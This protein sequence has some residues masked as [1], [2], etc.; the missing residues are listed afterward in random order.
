MAQSK[1]VL[2]FSLNEENIEKYTSEIRLKEFIFSFDSLSPDTPFKSLQDLKFFLDE[3]IEI[4]HKLYVIV[5]YRS[6]LSSGFP[7][8]NAKMLKSIILTYPEVQ[9]AF[10]EEG[11]E[12]N[13]IKY[14]FGPKV[15]D[16][17]I[18]SIHVFDFN[19]E[20][21]LHKLL[22]QN[23]NLFDASNLRY[24]LKL[25]KYQDLHVRQNFNKLQSRRKDNLA[26]VIDEERKQSLFN[27]YVLYASG[28]RVLPITTAT[29][30]IEINNKIGDISSSI[31]PKLILRDYDLQ[32]KD[33]N[34][35]SLGDR[36][37]PAIL[38]LH[39]VEYNGS[40]KKVKLNVVDLIR[41][42]KY[43]DPQV[44][45]R[46]TSAVARLRSKQTDTE[47]STTANN[48]TDQYQWF[49]FLDGNNMYWSNMLNIPTY[50]VTKSDRK[51]GIA[52]VSPD[53]KEFAEV[54]SPVIEGPDRKIL[55][56]PGI[57]K[58][59]TGIYKEIQRIPLV[60]ENYE[61]C[62]YGMYDIYDS[63]HSEDKTVSF[64]YPIKTEREANN[65]ST[66]L[67]LYEM[68]QS[69]VKRA[70]AYYGSGKY[71]YAALLASE[72]IEVM[73][74]FHL[75]L[76]LKAYYINAVAENALAVRLLGADE[77]KLK[78]DTWFRLNVKIE[79]DLD[80]MCMNAPE[81]KN[82]LLYNI[83]NESRNFSKSREQFESAEISLSLSVHKT[84]RLWRSLDKPFEKIRTLFFKQPITDNDVETDM[85]SMKKSWLV[86]LLSKM[87]SV[88]SKTPIVVQD[89]IRYLC[90][91]PVAIF[92]LVG[93]CLASMILDS[94]SV[95]YSYIVYIAL[96]LTVSVFVL[97]PMQIVYG[98]VGT[99]GDIRKFIIMFT[100][101]IFS[102]T[103][104]YFWG[105]LKDAGVTYNLDVPQIEY[106]LFSEENSHALD[107]DYENIPLNKGINRSLGQYVS[108]DHESFN[109]NGDDFHYYKR[110][111][112]WFVLR[113]T[114]LS[115]MT[116]SPSDFFVAAS[117]NYKDNSVDCQMTRLFNLVV[118]FQVLFSW[119]FLGVFISL[120][121]QKFRNE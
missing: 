74:G 27:G 62:R 77:E 52:V 42:F 117:T 28:Y 84:H 95:A 115:A 1:Y 23:N 30:L 82:N 3:K 20:F 18:P 112:Y 21:A 97:K 16:G 43:A 53:A 58:P 36:E 50:F 25:K 106:S 121:Y 103:G 47:E 104:I 51:G 22:E 31:D 107:L 5:D 49:S 67:D 10:Q 24:H 118:L 39:E 72:A 110:I 73:N 55:K 9:F 102:F 56:V 11:Q 17:L 41:G 12:Y 48:P 40:K 13:Y 81:L 4:L 7:E 105:F 2:Y 91:F 70:E 64:A 96:A 87:K 59:V 100:F 109:H 45:M 61:A 79:E 35:V 65:H 90:D 75:T 34:G 44:L 83:Y 93:L 78:Q 71:L 76:M 46:S 37:E 120:I 57:S 29:E 89:F 38:N 54:L 26:L 80:R 6:L 119:I 101:V 111:N 116:S 98:V 68:V 60:K 69:L 8:R 113:Q 33:E 86:R 63:T 99:K 94:Q 15:P 114:A 66:P 32:F 14:I 88:Y 92:V 108:C 85:K 19:D